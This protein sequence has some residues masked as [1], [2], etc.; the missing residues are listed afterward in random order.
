MIGTVVVVVVVATN[1]LTVIVTMPNRWI[2]EYNMLLL[3]HGD[4]R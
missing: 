2:E 3:G 1:H 4:Q